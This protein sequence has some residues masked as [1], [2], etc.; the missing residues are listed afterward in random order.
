MGAPG[1]KKLQDL[2][3]DR[4]IPRQW[5][6]RIPVFCDREGPFW[7]PGLAVDTRVAVALDAEAH[8]CIKVLPEP[9]L[10]H[11]LQCTVALRARN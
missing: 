2:M 10:A 11:V 8:Y 7:A 5:R 3:I 1:T 9:E 6:D 4:K